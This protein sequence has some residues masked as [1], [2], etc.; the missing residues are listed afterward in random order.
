M[1][2]GRRPRAP[3]RCFANLEDPGTLARMPGL[4]AD[5]DVI[6]K[7]LASPEQ[8]IPQVGESKLVSTTRTRPGRIM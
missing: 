5:A 4:D 1:V 2:A 6:E 7:P 8:G 3:S